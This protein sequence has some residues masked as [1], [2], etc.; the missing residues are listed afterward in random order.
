[1]VSREEARECVSHHTLFF[2]FPLIF[3]II[4]RYQQVHKPYVF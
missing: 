3:R 4:R 1:M 2:L